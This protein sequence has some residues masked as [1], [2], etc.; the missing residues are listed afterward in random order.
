VTRSEAIPA[1]LILAVVEQVEHGGAVGTLS[2]VGRYVG[3]Q[4]LAKVVPSG[5]R[6]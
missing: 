5:H 3:E 2:L 4:L 1:E 6:S